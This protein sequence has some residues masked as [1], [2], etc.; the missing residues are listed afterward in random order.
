MVV[1]R[2]AGPGPL[3]HRELAYPPVH[4]GFV[5]ATERLPFELGELPKREEKQRVEHAKFIVAVAHDALFGVGC[6]SS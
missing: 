2:L 3:R 1:V 6:G 5:H 4:Q